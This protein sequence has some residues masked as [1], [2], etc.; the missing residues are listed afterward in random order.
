[1]PDSDH[2]WA[3]TEE[4]WHRR[5]ANVP[6]TTLA[7]IAGFFDGEGSVGL[8]HHKR[9][10]NRYGRYILQI[11]VTN[12]VQRSV[13]LIQETFRGTVYSRPPVEGRQ[14]VYQ[15]FASGKIGERFLE[16]ISPYLVIKAPQVAL[17]LE[18][19]YLLR[20][21]GAPYGSI[22]PAMRERL[23]EIA[24]AVRNL[25]GRSPQKQ[26]AKRPDYV[27]TPSRYVDVEV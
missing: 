26:R 12:T 22:P 17:V 5:L 21:K 6:P 14:R 25:N 24:I 15:W 7:W 3:F 27:A 4:E 9:P 18:A 11:T 10:G 8:Y 13:E 16:A 23:D 20:G 1:M 2:L 19:R